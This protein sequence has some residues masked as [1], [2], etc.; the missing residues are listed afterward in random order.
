VGRE[1]MHRNCSSRRHSTFGR[2]DR[3]LQLYSCV[4]SQFLVLYFW[5]QNGRKTLVQKAQIEGCLVSKGSRIN[6]NFAVSWSGPMGIEP[7][8]HALQAIEYTGFPSLVRV[9]LR[10]TSGN[11]KRPPSPVL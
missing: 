1:R 2:T 3:R 8:S 6:R 4:S 10:P 11:L 7:T 9:Q 5:A